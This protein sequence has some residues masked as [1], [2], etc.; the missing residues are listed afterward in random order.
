[1][2]VKQTGGELPGKVTASHIDLVHGLAMHKTFLLA[3]AVMSATVPELLALMPQ[4]LPD[5]VH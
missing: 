4:G 1:M 2:I 3:P 5:T